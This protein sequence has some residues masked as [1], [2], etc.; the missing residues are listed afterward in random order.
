MSEQTICAQ[1]L[2][3]AGIPF[4]SC[5]TWE[6][7]QTYALQGYTVRAIADDGHMSKQ[8]I[9]DLCDAELERYKDCFG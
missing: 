9:Q 6:S 2:N 4:D 3:G 8:E 5:Y 1:V 7:A